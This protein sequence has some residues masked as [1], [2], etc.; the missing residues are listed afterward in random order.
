MNQ[1][2][3]GK[4]DNDPALSLWLRVENEI[5]ERIIPHLD[6]I[7]IPVGQIAADLQLSVMTAALE[8]DIS[9]LIRRA[10]NEEE[11]YEVK[12]NVADAPARQRFTVAHEIGHF[13]LHRHLIG[14]EGITDTVLFRSRLS[15]R[16][17]A[18]AN[19]IAASLLLPWDSVH[20]YCTD[21]FGAGP[22]EANIAAVARAYV[23]S[24]LTVGYRFGF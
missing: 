23:V 6:L 20:R 19:R 16:Q 7:P 17:E 5:V 1:R 9:G 24:E 3:G 15:N 12:V 11:R 18:E 21:K 4:L 13:A 2:W 22:S 10:P 8:P 14:A